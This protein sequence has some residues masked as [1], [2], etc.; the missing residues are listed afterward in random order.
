MFLVFK[1][2]ALIMIIIIPFFSV[3]LCVLT[4]NVFLVILVV[5]ILEN[6]K[7]IK[8]AGQPWIA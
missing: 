6:P 2:S 7:L 1:K 3:K 5:K 8:Q 4:V